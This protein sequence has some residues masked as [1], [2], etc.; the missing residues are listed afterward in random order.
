MGCIAKAALLF[1]AGTFAALANDS[2]QCD[3]IAADP[4]EG[5]PACTRLIESG[6]KSTNLAAVYNNRGTG[7]FSKGLYDN[8]IADFSEA[9]QRNPRLT[10]AF[11]NRGRSWYKKL[12]FDRSISDLNAAIKLEP[13]NAQTYG[14][15]GASLQNKGEFH[16]AVNDFTK[17]IE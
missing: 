2:E 7:W 3:K 5:I 8:A 17:A 11:R 16:L 4:D 13:K 10:I 14:D 1:F 6:A 9:I 15:R 12:D